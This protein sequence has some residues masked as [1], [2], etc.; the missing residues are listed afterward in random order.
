MDLQSVACTSLSSEGTVDRVILGW[1]RERSFADHLMEALEDLHV[2]G[3]PRTADTGRA[4]RV[5]MV[6]IEVDSDRISSRHVQIVDAS[7]GKVG[8][9]IYPVGARSPPGSAA[10]WD[11]GTGRG[12]GPSFPAPS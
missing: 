7:P 4:E 9:I 6:Q 8:R 1:P 11:C 5:P 12:D 3:L 10:Y 2:F